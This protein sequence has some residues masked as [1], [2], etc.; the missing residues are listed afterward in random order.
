MELSIGGTYFLLEVGG[1][2]MCE[3]ILGCQSGEPYFEIL[4]GEAR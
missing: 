3:R 1:L 2:E 4:S